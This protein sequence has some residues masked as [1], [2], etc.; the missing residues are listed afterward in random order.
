MLLQRQTYAK[1]LIFS[2]KENEIYAC[3]LEFMLSFDKMQYNAK[4]LIFS[5][6]ENEMYACVLEFMLSF[7]KMQ[8]NSHL[9]CT[10]F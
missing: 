5:E 3:V 1:I 4:I 9:M 2:E 7:D 6:K 8:Y 10:E